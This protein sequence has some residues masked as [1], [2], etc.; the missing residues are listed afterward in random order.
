MQLEAFHLFLEANP[1]FRTGKSRVLLVLLGSSRNEEDTA[2]IES[3]KQLA[4][5]LNVLVS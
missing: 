4:A 3:L 1:H 5:N 2:R